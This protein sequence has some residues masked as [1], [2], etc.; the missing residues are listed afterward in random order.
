[1][2]KNI[3]LLILISIFMIG[4]FPK[5]TD[6]NGKY[7]ARVAAEK[8]LELAEKAIDEDYYEEAYQILDFVKSHYP[9]ELEAQERVK[10][11]YGDV[12]FKQSKYIDAISVYQAFIKIHPNSRFVPYA[13]FKIAKSYYNDM[14]LEFIL[15][16]PP[17]ERD[18][19]SIIYAK[20]A[21]MFY[22]GSYPKSKNIK[23]AKKMLQKTI[24]YLAN[25]QF[26]VGNFYFDR[27]KYK[28]AVRR[29]QI[30]II[31]H[32]DSSYVKESIYKSALSYIRLKDGENAK[33][34]KELYA[35]KYPKS[36]ELR[37]INKE[38]KETKF[39]STEKEENKKTAIK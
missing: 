32:P 24:D 21:L 15:F 29:F 4:C 23:E 20:K 11:L 30:V 13:Q 8:N 25:Y 37:N 9:Y 39:E 1:M 7:P 10:V 22:V 18:K 14:P 36:E 19:E 38:F 27:E 31:E 33:K 28:G 6:Y 34:Y 35:K 2:N 16:P 12:L 5:P 17:Y 26:Y 3:V